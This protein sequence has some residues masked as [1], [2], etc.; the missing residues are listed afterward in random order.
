MWPW[1]ASTQGFVYIFHLGSPLGN[2]TNA[3][4]QATHYVGF[5]EDINARLAKHFAGKGSP[6]IASAIAR[7]IPLT[8][9]HWPAP[10]ATEKL[11]KAYK[12]TS[13]FCP[14]CAA[15][16]GRTSHPLPMPAPLQL[17]LDLDDPMPDVL[18]QGRMGWLEVQISSAWRCQR[19]PVPSGIDDDLL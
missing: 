4:A 11:V 10:L 18:D 7:Q 19:I 1:S 16:A 17:M 3:R 13:V 15:A 6:L 2:L 12:K 9:Y 8:V 14:A 5:A